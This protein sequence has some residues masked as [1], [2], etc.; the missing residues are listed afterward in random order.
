MAEEDSIANRL[1]ALREGREGSPLVPVTGREQGKLHAS[2]PGMEGRTARIRAIA[3]KVRTITPFEATGAPFEN[4]LFT[5]QLARPGEDK[6]LAM[7]RAEA[8]FRFRDDI[9]RA[10][11]S[12]LSAKPIRDSGGGGGSRSTVADVKIYAMQSIG[13]L[14]DNMPRGT[15]NLLE[16][17]LI[18]DQWLLDA[19][20]PK[21]KAKSGAERRR[22]KKK[23][24]AHW[25]LMLNQV[26]CGLDTLAVHYDLLRY[27]EFAER[28]PGASYG[29]S[30][31]ISDR[32]VSE[33]GAGD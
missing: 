19:P 22:Q 26:L 23:A 28:W 24:E 21:R 16:A 18:N 27:P 10:Q 14:R 12:T 31:V 1:K 32:D 33:A 7:L 5:D 13:R 25:E 11:L 29:R 17:F 3:D 4:L 30:Q 20:K 9:E 8:G 2:L 15:F 6:D